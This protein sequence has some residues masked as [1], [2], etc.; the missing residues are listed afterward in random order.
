MGLFKNK[1]QERW[2]QA[3]ARGDT[4]AMFNLGVLADGARDLDAARAWWV[5][6]ANLGNPGAMNR[7]GFLAQQA[8]DKD[9]ARAWWEQAAKLGHPHA[10]NRLGSLASEARELVMRPQSSSGFPKSPLGDLKWEEMTNEMSSAYP[11]F[12]GGA[13]R[14]LV[15]ARQMASELADYA[16]FVRRNPH[17]SLAEWGTSDPDIVAF[18]TGG[19]G[20]VSL[21]SRNVVRKILASGRNKA[22]GDLKHAAM[23]QAVAEARTWCPGAA[24]KARE[25]EAL[26]IKRG[27]HREREQ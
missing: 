10:M 2:E 19:Y 9:A 8:G 3:A 6:A 13:L 14:N 27:N 22:G 17:V 11:P 4:E 7:L 23:R 18:L 26:A 21:E 25:R 24:D 15:E 16:C 20:P 5:Q 1:K 12:S